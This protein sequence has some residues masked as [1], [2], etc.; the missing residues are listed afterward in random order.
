MRNNN[1]HKTIGL[2]F[3]LKEDYRL[4]KGDPVDRYAEFDVKA[5][6]DIVKKAIEDNGHKVLPL[7]DIKSLLNLRGRPQVDIVFNLAEGELGRNR[8]SQVPMFLEFLQLPFVGGDALTLGIS[9]DKIMTKKIFIAEGIPTP[10]FFQA[11]NASD[12]GTMKLKYPLIVKP[13]FEGSS[14]GVN[15]ESLIYDF[16]NL[17]KRVKWLIET[18]QQSALIEEFIMGKEFTVPI[19]GNDKPTVYCPVQIK[20][21]GK[22]KLGDLFYTFERITSDKLEYIY[23]AKINKALTERIRKL[24]LAAY[25]A[26]ECRDFGRVD[27]R[28]NEKNEIFVLE[29]NPLP[30]LS[31]DDVFMK[32]AEYDGLKFSDVIGEILRSAFKRYN[33]N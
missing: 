12:L 6:I 18:Y 2:T 13:R 16:S 9:L 20:I 17:K 1:N 19:I 25:Q 7:G 3:D 15:Q 27:F 23:P 30:S 28:V 22:L 32:I 21:D 11:N 4:K 10:A 29:V 24:A 31:T 8:E 26:V 5:T 33:W 14:K